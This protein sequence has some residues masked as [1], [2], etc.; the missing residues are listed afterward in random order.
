MEDFSEAFKEVKKPGIEAIL[1]GEL[2]HHLGYM[3]STHDQG[4]GKTTRGMGEQSETTSSKGRRIK[5][6][7]SAGSTGAVCAPGD[8]QTQ[9]TV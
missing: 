7:G 4:R 6:S 9:D 8:T 3:I 2:T 5:G 1:S